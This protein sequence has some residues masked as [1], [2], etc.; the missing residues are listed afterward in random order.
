MRHAA[1][2]GN[3]IG[4]VSSNA[5]E[6]GYKKKEKTKST[7]AESRTDSQNIVVQ[8]ALHPTNVDRN[9]TKLTKR[10]ALPF[11]SAPNSTSTNHKLL[12]SNSSSPCIFCFRANTQHPLPH[13]QALSARTAGMHSLA[14]LFY[15]TWQLPGQLRLLSHKDAPRASLPASLSLHTTVHCPPQRTF[16][17]SHRARPGVP[18]AC[19]TR[20]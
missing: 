8:R 4:V 6:T 9:S 20:C 14:Q 5:K 15:T 16:I 10:P 12:Q 19:R 13:N 2:Q 17:H 11:P 3:R 18:H 7:K 1:H